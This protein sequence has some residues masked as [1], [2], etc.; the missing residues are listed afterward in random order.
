MHARTLPQ[1]VQLIQQPIDG[2]VRDKVVSVGL[3]ARSFRCGI[4]GECAGFG[5]GV[6]RFSDG[7]RGCYDVAETEGVS[8]DRMIVRV[9][10]DARG[11]GLE[12]VVALGWD[13]RGCQVRCVR[14]GRRT[15][16]QTCL[17][18]S[19]ASSGA[20]PA[21]SATWACFKPLAAV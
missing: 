11:S 6:V 15:R 4:L 2:E 10:E 20:D 19:P 1:S 16:G 5:K 8:F 9:R 17:Y 12:H 3:F 21:R 13:G 18:Q 14:S 7:F